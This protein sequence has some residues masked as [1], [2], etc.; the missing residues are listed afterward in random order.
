MHTYYSLGFLILVFTLSACGGDSSP[1]PQTGEATPDPVSSATP[2][3]T[4]APTITST[5]SPTGVPTVTPEPTSEP[6][7]I[8]EIAGPGIYS[9]NYGQFSG[10]YALLDDN[11]FF[12]IHY[13]VNNTILAGHPRGELTDAN[14]VTS[15][16]TIAWANFIDDAE[17]LGV[18]EPNPN[19]GRT[20]IPGG[21]EVR[22]QGS[23]GT[24]STTAIGQ[25]PWS[26]NS[27]LTL[28]DVPKPVAELSGTYS[29][30]LRTVGISEPR[31]TF[32]AF[33]LDDVGNYAVESGSC[34]YTGVITP[35]G[36]TGLFE[37]SATASGN[38]CSMVPTLS[39]ILLPLEYSA[40]NT[41]LA[42]LLNND[43]QTHTA[44]FVVS[45]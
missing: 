22:I 44:V 28:Y 35:L 37:T 16:D 43:E 21:V 38:D 20:F 32:T 45:K 13:V 36:A 25:R 31:Q 39:G 1:E 14:S 40:S 8:P 4:T 6:T 34:T 42:F 33:S 7:A 23:F 3:P 17:Q 18:Q 30:E 29:G 11:R 41:E 5:P 9:V 26:E 15:R 2:T 24:F 12:G 27:D 10:V 19:F